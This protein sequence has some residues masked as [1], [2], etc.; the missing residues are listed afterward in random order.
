MLVRM[1]KE[2]KGWDEIEKAW[3]VVTGT[4]PGK[5]VLRKKETKLRALAVEWKAGDVR[6]SYLFFDFPLIGISG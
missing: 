1:R 2:G 5:D 3:T 4:V 6:F